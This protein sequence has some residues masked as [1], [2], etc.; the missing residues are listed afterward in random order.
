MSSLWWI[1]RINLQIMTL[2]GFAGI[3]I[4]EFW[5]KTKDSDTFFVRYSWIKFEIFTR[6]QWTTT[7]NSFILVPVNIKHPRL[8]DVMGSCL[9]SLIVVWFHLNFYCIC[10]TQIKVWKP[11]PTLIYY[12]IFSFNDTLAFATSAGTNSSVNGKWMLCRISAKLRLTNA[13]HAFSHGG[14]QGSLSQG[15]RTVEEMEINPI[16][17]QRVGSLWYKFWATEVTE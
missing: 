17:I 9:K 16:R 15:P 4:I 11:W 7:F 3:E 8:I 1:C 6:S 12:F 2:V 13:T 10:L 5:F 14:S